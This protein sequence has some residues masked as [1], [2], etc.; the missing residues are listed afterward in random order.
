MEAFYL[1]MNTPLAVEYTNYRGETA[2]RTIVPQQIWYGSTEYHP[3]PQWLVTA[4]DVERAV[5]RDFALK[6]MRPVKETK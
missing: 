4:F 1:R 2:I 6:D 5:G 3:E